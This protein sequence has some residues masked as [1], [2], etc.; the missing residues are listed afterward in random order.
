MVI[1]RNPTQK[2]A[3]TVVGHAKFLTGIYRM[4]RIRDKIKGVISWI[5]CS[6]LFE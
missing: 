6:S 4:D 3:R 5:S 1:N 2:G